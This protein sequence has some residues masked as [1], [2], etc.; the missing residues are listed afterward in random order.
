M[1]DRAYFVPVEEE[2]V[3]AEDVRTS[4]ADVLGASAEA[5]RHVADVITTNDSADPARADVAA[6]LVELE[7]RR[8]HLSSLLLVDPYADAGAWEQ[9]GAMLSAVDRLRV[10]VAA[11]VRAPTANWRPP[12]VTERQRRAIRRLVDARADRVRARRHKPPS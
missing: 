9:H 2:T 3:Y 12:P 6:A 4:L 5:M 7:R 1:L 10:E 8:D 11:T